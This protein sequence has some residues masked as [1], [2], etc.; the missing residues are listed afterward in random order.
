MLR[1]V[2]RIAMAA[3]AMLLSVTAA[4][5]TTFNVS[6][7]TKTAEH[8]YF[9]QGEAVGYVVD[10]VQGKEVVVMRGA[11]YVFQMNNVPEMHPFYIT[12]SAIGAGADP[13]TDGVTG[14][15]AVGNQTLTFTPSSSAP[16]LLYYQ[17]G[18][19][20]NMGWRIVVQGSPSGIAGELQEHGAA[21]VSWPN[22]IVDRGMIAL[23]SSASTSVR[24]ALY[25]MTGRVVEELF[26]GDV[27]AGEQLSVGLDASGLVPGIYVLH[28]SGSGISSAIPVAIR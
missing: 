8:P 5:Q 1:W 4:A 12:T 11:T 17:C 18:F 20:S 15:G 16:D 9:G 6:V 10:G 26:D 23:R 13:Y 27:V 24:L 7:A 28:A 14:N 25:D 22:P 3:L 2:S 19:H 21:M